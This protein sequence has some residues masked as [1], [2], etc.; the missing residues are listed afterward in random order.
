MDVASGDDTVVTVS[1]LFLRF[2]FHMMPPNRTKDA[3]S[4]GNDSHDSCSSIRRNSSSLKLNTYTV[5][6]VREMR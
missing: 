6:D 5:R 3:L 1:S 4:S 2:S